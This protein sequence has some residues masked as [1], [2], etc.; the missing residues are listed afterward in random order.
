MCVCVCVCVASPFYFVHIMIKLD[1]YRNL[2]YKLF[3]IVTVEP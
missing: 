1:K 3:E 2:F